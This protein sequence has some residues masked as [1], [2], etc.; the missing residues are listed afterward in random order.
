MFV[1]VVILILRRGR[2]GRGVG[3]VSERVRHKLRSP[4][5]EEGA[6]ATA[7]SERGAGRPGEEGDAEEG[8][9]SNCVGKHPCTHTLHG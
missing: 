3:G 1:D 9:F 7:R 2:R 6:G 5:D 4:E 8:P